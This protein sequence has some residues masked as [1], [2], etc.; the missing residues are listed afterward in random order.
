MT[1]I[2]DIHEDVRQQIID[3]TKTLLESVE[4]ENAH[5]SIN[6]GDLYMTP[7]QFQNLLGYCGRRVS[8]RRFREY[9]R[10]PLM[11][12]NHPLSPFF[13]VHEQVWYI[14]SPSI[15]GGNTGHRY[16]IPVH[17]L[18][19]HVRG[20]VTQKNLAQPYTAPARM[21]LRE[22]VRERL[23]SLDDHR[24]VMRKARETFPQYSRQTVWKIIKTI[25]P[26]HPF[27]EE[28]DRENVSVVVN[29]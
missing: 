15:R 8:R 12:P 16:I 23:R 18:Q 25:H 17:F 3:I 27:P 28:A 14:V 26:T 29:R 24:T 13:C 4:K 10:Y 1:T 9:L 22:F 5:L 21:A 7:T 11:T 19:A 6:A 2:T 20:I